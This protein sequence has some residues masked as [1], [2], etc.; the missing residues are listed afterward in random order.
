MEIYVLLTDVT[1]GVVGAPGTS[2]GMISSEL[3]GVPWPTEFTAITLNRYFVPVII[4]SVVDVRVKEMTFGS[5]IILIGEKLNPL[6][7]S[8]WTM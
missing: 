5:V 8:H 3:E 1:T 4:E 7:E 6:P 2:A